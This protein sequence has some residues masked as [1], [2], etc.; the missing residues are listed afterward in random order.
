M[1]NFP[2]IFTS[3]IFLIQACGTDK[4]DSDTASGP[5]TPPTSGTYSFISKPAQYTCTD[6]SSGT[7]TNQVAKNLK[8]TISGNTIK[9]APADQAA[10][11]RELAASG[12]TANVTGYSG[13]LDSDGKS[14]TLSQTGSGT[15]KELGNFN[16]NYTLTGS[17]QQTQWSGTVT[18]TLTF[19]SL[20]I[21]CDYKSTFSGTKQP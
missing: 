9:L 18:S 16:A 19:F 5:V 7:A 8:M 11:D 15:M 2:K 14:F 17:L 1:N 6:G 13:L 3:L 12:I 4:T 21:S 10:E 20:G